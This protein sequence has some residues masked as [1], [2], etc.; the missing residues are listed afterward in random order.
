MKFQLQHRPGACNRVADALSRYPV[1][2][3]RENARKDAQQP[4]CA[5]QS[6]CN[7]I[8][9]SMRYYNCNADITAL[10]AEGG[11]KAKRCDVEE[12]EEDVEKEGEEH[13]ET[14]V[15]EVSEESLKE[16]QKA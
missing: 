5:V 6:F 1:P 14:V 3:E 13:K 7:A 15:E 16:A 11:R 4:A 2:V 10:L 12:G 9:Q 8:N